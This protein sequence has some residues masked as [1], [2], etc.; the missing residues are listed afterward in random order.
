MTK[1]VIKLIQLKFFLTNT[2][3]ILQM[4]DPTVFHRAMRQAAGLFIGNIE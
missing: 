1:Q 3:I 2:D 4:L